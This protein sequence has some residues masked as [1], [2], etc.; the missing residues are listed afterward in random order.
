[1]GLVEMQFRLE[2]VH[3]LKDKRSIV[4]PVLHKLRNN[5][6]CAAMESDLLDS[7]QMMVIMAV[8]LNSAGTQLEMTL[9]KMIETAQRL[10]PFDMTVSRR[11]VWQ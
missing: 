4:Q 6:N 2:G 8:T 7:H 9:N 3:S 11:E 10:A 5:F 1:V